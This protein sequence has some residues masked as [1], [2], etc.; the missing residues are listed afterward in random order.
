MLWK[1]DRVMFRVLVWGFV[2]MC[3]FVSFR[4]VLS[5]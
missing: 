2:W 4:V 1:L 5:C 3:L